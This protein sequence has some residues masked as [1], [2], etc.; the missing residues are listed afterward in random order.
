MLLFY[1]KKNCRYIIK[2]RGVASRSAHLKIQG[3]PNRGRAM[4]RANVKNASQ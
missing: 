3:E 1:I 2:N 4:S